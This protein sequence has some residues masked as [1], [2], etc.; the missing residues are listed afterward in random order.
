MTSTQARA[1][2]RVARPLVRALAA[3][4]ISLALAGPAA[5]AAEIKPGGELRA[6]RHRRI[7]AVQLPEIDLVDAQPVAAA[8]RLANE[9]VGIAVR[10]PGIRT[11]APQA[12]L[13]RDM[14]APAI[15]MQRLANELLRHVGPIGVGRV[16]EVDAEFRDSPQR[17][18]RLGPVAGR[19]PDSRTGDPHRAEAEAGNGEIA[20]DREGAGSCGIGVRHFE[21]CFGRFML[22]GGHSSP[23]S[24]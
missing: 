13:R 8:M 18:Q 11:R 2:V 3:F 19:P 23:A 22:S 24:G 7:D 21:S 12:G 9:I 10:L 1:G 14:D 15:G 20:A 5:L 4:S 16:D 6:A 17:R